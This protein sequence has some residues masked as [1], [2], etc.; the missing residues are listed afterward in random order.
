MFVVAFD[1]GTRNLAVCALQC[2][3]N[4][5]SLTH[6]MNVAVGSTKN[7]IAQLVECYVCFCRAQWGWLSKADHVVIELQVAQNTRMKCAAS[8]VQSLFNFHNIPVRVMPARQKFKGVLSL[9]PEWTGKERSAQLKHLAVVACR[10][11]LQEHSEVSAH[12]DALASHRLFLGPQSRDNPKKL[13][14]LADALL[15]AVTHAYQA[16]LIP[17]AAEPSG[18]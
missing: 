13:D 10:R 15:Q 11:W 7:T 18:S 3:A 8:A 16:G 9:L 2:D 4:A 5:T 17:D 12:A 6:W 14:D 1:M